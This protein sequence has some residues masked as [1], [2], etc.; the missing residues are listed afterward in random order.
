MHL[1]LYN[2][3]TDFVHI[4]KWIYDERT[5]ALWCA[6]QLPYPLSKDELHSYLVEQ[7]LKFSSRIQSETPGNKNEFDGAYVY[8]D[9][10]NQPIGFLIYTV[11]AQDKSG[12]LRFIIVDNTLRGKG[13]GTEML[14]EFQRFAYNN[15]GVSSIRLIVFDANIVAHKCYEKAEFT[16]IE[17]TQDAFSYRDE[18]WGRCLMEHKMDEEKN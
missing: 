14:R 3:Q 12:F 16:T 7:N 9:E 11:N 1:R 8:A 18:M 6:N 5:H 10:D 4:G 15:T 13:Y 17:N 2:E